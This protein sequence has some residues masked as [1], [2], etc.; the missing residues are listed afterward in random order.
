MDVVRGNPSLFMRRDEVDAAWSWI[1]TILAGWE[2]TDMRPD[3]Y[4][5]GGWGPISAALL[6]DRDGRRWHD[7]EL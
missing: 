2:Q 3:P 6:L 4:A 1:D 7:P 5:A